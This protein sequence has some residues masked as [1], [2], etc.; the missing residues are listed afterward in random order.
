MKKVIAMLLCLFTMFVFV[1]CNEANNPTTEQSVE[2]EN[3]IDIAERDNLPT[4]DALELFYSDDTYDYYF[5]S[6]RSMYVIVYYN[7]GAKQT[8]QDALAEGKIKISDL[9]SFGIHYIKYH[10]EHTDI[11]TMTYDYG[12]IIENTVT[13]LFNGGFFSNVEF[14][15]SEIPLVAGDKFVFKHNGEFVS[16]ETYPAQIR[17]EGEIVN[18]FYMYT[19]IR[20]V[21]EEDI[22]RNE[23]GGI[24][25]I[26]NCAYTT[27]YVII[28][29]EMEFVKLSEYKGEPLYFA[30][31]PSMYIS[32]DSNEPQPLSAAA[33]YAY[34]PRPN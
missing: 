27:E 14:E 34:N 2:I 29:E 9:D 17:F 32:D 30:I 24:E 18:T 10:S 13:E 3:I 20:A 28:N 33:F 6:I 8:V 21:S 23:N 22:V 16:L 4:D 25:R 1:S 19:K 5:S 12:T 31:D 11:F 7:G 26:N 15:E